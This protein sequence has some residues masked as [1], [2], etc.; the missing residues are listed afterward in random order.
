MGSVITNLRTSAKPFLFLSAATVVLS[1]FAQYIWQ[2]VWTSM[3]LL[4][5]QPPGVY[6]TLIGTG[7]SFAAWLIYQGTRDRNRLLTLMFGALVAAWGIHLALSIVHSDNFNH[8][9]WAYILLILMLWFKTPR[10][11]DFV[12]ALVLV[13]WLISAILVATRL[14]ELLG[15][16]PMA[17]VSARLVGF[18][19]ANY[20]LPLSGWLGPEGRWPGPF[21]HNAMTGNI[22]AYLIVLGVAL[23]SRSGLVFSV[24][25]VTTLLLTSSRSSF[26]ATA[27][28]VTL[29]VL[30]GDYRWTRRFDRRV[31]VGGVLAVCALAVTAALWA[32]PNLTGRTTYWPAFIRLW[33]TSPWIGVGVTGKEAGERLIA[34][35]NGHNLAI[36]SL[37]KYG[38]LGLIPVLAVLIVVAYICLRAATRGYV[39][40]L[41]IAATFFVI[42]LSESDYGWIVA[43]IPWLLLVLAALAAVRYLESPVTKRASA[44]PSAVAA[45]Q[46]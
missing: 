33:E 23:R 17:T 18:E 4:K 14:L 5:A 28:G 7:L 37:A 1:A 21:G 31:L 26:V 42:G 34:Q 29:V 22:A 13:G 39:L 46:E 41:G 15:V 27:I 2:Y 20:W 10:L 40:P 24:V 44:E 45:S 25:G 35:T 43:S 16:I 38:V 8:G 32:S 19:K 12:A 11:E 36:D 30:L 9:V 3:P 6:V